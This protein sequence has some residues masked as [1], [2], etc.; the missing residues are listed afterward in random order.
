MTDDVDMTDEEHAHQAAY[1]SRLRRHALAARI[2]ELDD[3]EQRITVAIYS[4]LSSNQKLSEPL[5]RI[6]NLLARSNK[7]LEWEQQLDAASV[8]CDQ[9]DNCFVQVRAELRAR[10]L[11]FVDCY[12]D[13]MRTVE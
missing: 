1:A 11:D 8:T 12:F 2:K 4:Y 7:Q 3:R 13:E 10:N 9:I 5:L 6:R